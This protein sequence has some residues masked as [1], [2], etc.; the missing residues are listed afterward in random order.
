[1]S[2]S[3]LFDFLPPIVLQNKTAAQTRKLPNLILPNLQHS[4]DCSVKTYNAASLT[5]W[6]LQKL[7]GL[8]SEEKKEM[9]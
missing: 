4:Q 3:G 9:V 1:M 6:N 8:F 2:F 5:I 7:S